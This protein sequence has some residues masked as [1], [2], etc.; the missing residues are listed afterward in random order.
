MTVAGAA[1]GAYALS[2]CLA[3]GARKGAAAARD[4]GFVAQISPC[5][6]PP[7]R[8]AG[9]SAFWH[10]ER[11]K[12]M[13][14]V[15]FQNDVKNKDIG[16]AAK[17]GFRSVEHLKRYTT[18]GMATDQGKLSNFPGLAILAKKL[19]RAFPKPA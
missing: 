3:E 14:F 6:K 17:E 16:L 11:S 9:L 5:P 18:L 15:D 12:G 13:A 2:A 10:V 19:G 4:L 8:P 1:S 7:T